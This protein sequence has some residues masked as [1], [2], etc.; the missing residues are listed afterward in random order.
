MPSQTST[1]SRR[2]R[3]SWPVLLAG[4]IGSL[5][6]AVGLSPTLAAF[7]AQIRNTVDTAGTGTLI[8]Q[9]TNADGSVICNSTDGGR[10]HP[11]EQRH[12][13]RHGH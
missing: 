5:L 4:S 7:T 1:P 3:L 13:E 12:P 10:V 6:L 2:R 9:E 8:M 11:V